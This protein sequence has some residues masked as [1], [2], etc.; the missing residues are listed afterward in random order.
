M[1][2]RTKSITYVDNLH[3]LRPPYALT[4]ALISRRCS[5]N[6]NVLKMGEGRGLWHLSWNDA[7]RTRVS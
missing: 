2:K 3:H 7:Y 4:T 6:S 5:G 1:V